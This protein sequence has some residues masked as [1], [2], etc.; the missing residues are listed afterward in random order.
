MKFTKEQLGNSVWILVIVLIVF[1]PVGFHAR[2][3][4][5]KLFASNADVIEPDKQNTLTNYDWRLTDLEGNQANFDSNRGEV[6]L[7]NLWAT[8]CPPC[9]A[10]LPSL[11]KLHK[12]Y[13]NKVNFVFVTHEDEEKVKQF[14]N[15][16]NYNDLPVYFGNSQV[17]EEL[18][19]KSIPA[20]YIINK[21]GKIVVDEKGAANW[22]SGSIRKLLDQLLKE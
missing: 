15:K 16:K 6:A 12:D 2:V 3:F 20:T 5:G 4:V 21:S 19:S 17:P 8:W 22:N 9:V 13:G 7:V 1:T 10:E 11:D 14:L 18:F